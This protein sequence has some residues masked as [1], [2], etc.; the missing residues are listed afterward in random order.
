MVTFTFIVFTLIKRKLNMSF[1]H[2]KTVEDLVDDLFVE[3]LIEMVMQPILLNQN[4]WSLSIM[5]KTLKFAHMSKHEVPF[6][7][8]GAK[9]LI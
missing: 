8:F 9:I 2:E 5:R 1:F 4:K 3:V 7:Y 6:L